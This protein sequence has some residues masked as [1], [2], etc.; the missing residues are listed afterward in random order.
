MVYKIGD[1]VNVMLC[2]YRE[3]V[4]IMDCQNLNS[5]IDSF[6]FKIIGKKIGCHQDGS[7]DELY[8]FISLANKKKLNIFGTYPVETRHVELANIPEEYLNKLTYY[9]HPKYINRLV[10][11]NKCKC[12]KRLRT[13]IENQYDGN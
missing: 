12:I 1:T 9:T 7:D 11:R 5:K 10:A 8:L 2:K 4:Q 13:K 6:D 3:F